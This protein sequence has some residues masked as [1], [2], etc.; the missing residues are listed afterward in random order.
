MK[1]LAK[2]S[3]IKVVVDGENKN[4]KLKILFF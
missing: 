4:V 1:G 2:H 3:L